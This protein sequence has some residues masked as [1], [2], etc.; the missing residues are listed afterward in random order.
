MAVKFRE[1]RGNWFYRFEVDH[2]RYQEYGFATKDEARA[3]E[4]KKIADVEAGKKPLSVGAKHL[5]F[6]EAARTF[7]DDYAR[8]LKHE[9][10][11]RCRLPF[12]AEVFKGKKL[13]EI[14]RDDIRAL[15]EAVKATGAKEHTA[16]HYHAH[17]KALFNW[18]IEE[19]ELPIRNPAEGVEMASVP[20]AR[21]RFL[22]P[23]EE[24]I[25]E[26]FLREH[27]PRLWPYYRLGLDTGLREANVCG[28]KVGDVDFVLG[29]IFVPHTKNGESGYIPI[30]DTLRP[31]LAGWMAGKSADQFVM[32]GYA[33]N[34]VSNQFTIACREAG[35]DDFTFHCLRHSFAYKLLSRGV[36]LYIV[37]KLLLH[38]DSRVTE[39]HY[40]HLAGS[41]LAA[42]VNGGGSSGRQFGVQGDVRGAADFPA[43]PVVGAVP[44]LVRTAEPVCESCGVG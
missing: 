44:A 33:A 41:D 25:L 42:A 9:K 5:T 13:V 10:D 19:K 17:V 30:K 24:K 29:Q 43:L 4:R 32:D 7:Y 38:K 31:L 14:T 35:I 18:W 39:Q 26:P 40:G 11:Y 8:T 12:I 16:N 3:A 22:Y 23:A 20:K 34:T 6:T 1:D 27:Y 36:S 2:T 28:M 15:R 21:V 37:S